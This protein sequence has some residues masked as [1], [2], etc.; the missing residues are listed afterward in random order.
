[1]TV[2]VVALVTVNDDEPWA[3]GEYFRVTGPLLE[4]AGAEI[5]KRFSV[6]EVVVGHRPAKTVV[7]VKYPSRAAVESVFGSPEYQAIK[8]VRDRAF[9]DYHVSIASDEDNQAEDVKA[10]DTA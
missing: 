8:P 6:N 10:I 3:L 2:T 5:V 9:S 4:R 1:M 7:I